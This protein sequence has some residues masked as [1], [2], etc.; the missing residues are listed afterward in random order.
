MRKNL[1]LCLGVASSPTI[2]MISAIRVEAYTF[3]VGNLRK[4]LLSYADRLET[5]LRQ[6][7]KIDKSNNS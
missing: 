3:P 6:L 5:R 2:E 7:N 1:T 4:A